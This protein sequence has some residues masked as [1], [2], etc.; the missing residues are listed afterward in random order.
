MQSSS[1]SAASS[2]QLVKLTLSTLGSIG[3]E[4]SFDAF[5]ETIPKKTLEHPEVSQPVLICK[6]HSPIRFE[7]GDAVPE[8]PNSKI[9]TDVCTTRQL[10]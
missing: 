3:N 8:N 6:R 2:R 5:F 1:L 10:T 4:A 7:V 9:S